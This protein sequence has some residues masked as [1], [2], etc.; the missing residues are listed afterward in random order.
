MRI[1]VCKWHESALCHQRSNHMLIVYFQVN[2][3]FSKMPPFYKI[4][5]QLLKMKWMETK[6][7]QVWLRKFGSVAGVVTRTVTRAHWL[8]M[9]GWS[10]V[11]SQSMNVPYAWK[12]T[13]TNMFWKITC[14]WSTGRCKEKIN[15]S[16]FDQHCK[17]KGQS[18]NLSLSLTLLHETV[19][20]D[21]WYTGLTSLCYEGI[22]SVFSLQ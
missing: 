7:C 17:W 4:C 10:A 1:R 14:R 8:V 13:H 3:G 20:N 16:Y 12:C 21:Y 15:M 5:C 6:I 18:H 2:G 19:I 22:F 11:R 9:S